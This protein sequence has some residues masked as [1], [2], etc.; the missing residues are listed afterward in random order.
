[1]A[2]RTL[3]LASGSPARL[4]LLTD[5]GFDPKVVVSGVREDDVDAPTTPLLT[6]AL[7]ER[8]ASAVADSTGDAVV[9]GCDSI[10]EFDGQ[11]LGKPSDRHQALEWLR[12]VRGG[13]GTLYTGHCVID[14]RTG[15]RAVD[16]AG[17]IVRFGATTDEELD[18]YLDT[19]ESL[20]VAGAFTLDGRSAPF[21]DGVDGDPSNVIGLSLPLFRSLLAQLDLSVMALWA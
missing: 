16:V 17:T 9:V 14:E 3:I 13:Q 19:G 18:A 21:I 12:S 8:K 11:R 2:D 7:A 15:R 10:L 20:S 1:M 6:Q 5:A 4:R